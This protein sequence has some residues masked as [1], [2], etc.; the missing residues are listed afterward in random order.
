MEIKY[1]EWNLRA[2]GG[3]EYKIPAFISKLVNSEDIFVLV[4]CRRRPVLS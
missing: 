3:T 4:E 2:M 1:L